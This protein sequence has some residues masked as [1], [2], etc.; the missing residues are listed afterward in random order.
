LP[1]LCAKGRSEFIKARDYRAF[2]DLRHPPEVAFVWLTAYSP[3]VEE[4]EEDEEEEEEEFQ[5]GWVRPWE[6]RLKRGGPDREGYS[7]T[8]TGTSPT[9]TPGAT[10]RKRTVP[11][12]LRKR[13][14]VGFSAA[15]TPLQA[16][17]TARQGDGDR[18]TGRARVQPGRGAACAGHQP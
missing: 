17:P 1:E 13:L 5:A 2:Y 16:R 10:A 3:D 8:F 18:R 15:P 6:I 12:A 9:T 4:D 14:T 7:V 11:A